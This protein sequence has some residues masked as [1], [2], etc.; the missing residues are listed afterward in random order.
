MF[1]IEKTKGKIGIVAP[2]ALL[3][4]PPYLGDYPK[5]LPETGGNGCQPD[6]V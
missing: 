6:W 3:Y 4:P 5:N 1:F 2:T